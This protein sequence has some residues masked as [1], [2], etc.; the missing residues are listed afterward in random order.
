VL[1]LGKL[2]AWAKKDG[3]FDLDFIVPNFMGGE[4]EF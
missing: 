1:G 3:D 4:I 2:A